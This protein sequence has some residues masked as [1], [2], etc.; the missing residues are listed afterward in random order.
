MPEFQQEEAAV[1]IARGQAMREARLP[2]SHQHNNQ[3]LAMAPPLRQLHGETML[4]MGIRTRSPHGTIT[5]G[6]AAVSPA[7]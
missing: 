4:T 1:K 7:V 2:K 6:N 3:P 5:G